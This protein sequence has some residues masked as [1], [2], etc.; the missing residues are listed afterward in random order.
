VRL[1]EEQSGT[2]TSGAGNFKQASSAGYSPNTYSSENRPFGQQQVA[3]GDT[4]TAARFFPCFEQEHD[5]FLYTAKASTAEREA[6]CEVVPPAESGR[7]NDHPTVKGLKLMRWLVRLATPPGGLCL[8]I[9]CGSGSTGVACVLEGFHFMGFDETGG[10]EIARRQD[11]VW[12]RK[13]DNVR[14]STKNTLYSRRWGCPRGIVLIVWLVC[15]F[16]RA[17]GDRSR[18]EPQAGVPVNYTCY[19]GGCVWVWDD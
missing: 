9:F 7:R 2:R 6:G 17:Q 11:R 5:P 19:S 16:R 3:Y 14:T 18:S 13:E 8:D 15:P 4:G 12:E 10:T 1:L